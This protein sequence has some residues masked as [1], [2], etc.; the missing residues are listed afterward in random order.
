ME[1]FTIGHSNHNPER[2]ARLL[3]DA[4]IDEIVDVRSTPYS[5]WAPFANRENLEKLL[6]SIEIHYLYLGGFLGGNIPESQGN[7]KSDRLKAY[8]EIRQVPAF[9]QGIDKLINEMDR[10]CVCI[11]CAEEDPESCHR[12]LLVGKSIIEHGINVIHLRGDGRRQSEEDLWKEQH[13]INRNQIG[14]PL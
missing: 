7:K 12:R 8:E 3:E 9:Q 10:R 6:A 5:Q 13:H 11:L 2:F 1:L 14:L 4:G